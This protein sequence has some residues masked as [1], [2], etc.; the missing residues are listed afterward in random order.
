MW[1]WRHAITAVVLASWCSS[2]SSNDNRCFSHDGAI[3]FEGTNNQW[4]AIST[5]NPVPTP[6]APAVP[7]FPR[8]ARP[9]NAPMNNA[10]AAISRWSLVMTRLLNLKR[11]GSVTSSTQTVVNTT[12]HMPNQVRW[13]WNTHTKICALV[14]PNWVF[15]LLPKIPCRPRLALINAKPTNVKAFVQAGKSLA[16]LMLGWPL[17]Q[18]ASAAA[19]VKNAC[20]NVPNRSQ[21]RLCGPI[22]SP[23][24]PK[25]EPSWKERREQSACWSAL[26]KEVSRRPGGPSKRRARAMASY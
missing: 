24:R 9:A 4:N 19:M 13:Y 5:L 16:P 3:F 8:I 7:S 1:S 25:K 2:L 6:K 21:I 23:R 12:V 11:L 10:T 26:W 22:L 14:V 15:S 20:I 18:N 17:F